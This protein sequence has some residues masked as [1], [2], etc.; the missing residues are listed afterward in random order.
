MSL[1][2]TR[3]IQLSLLFFC[4]GMT[5]L[6]YEVL[7]LK[8]LGLL[9]GNT[10]QAMASTLAAFFLGLAVGGFYWGGK[11]AGWTNRLKLYAM[12]EL[13]VVVCAAGYFGL[14]KLYASIYP[15][16]FECCGNN[17]GLFIAVKFVLSLIILFPAAFFIGG[18]LPVMSHFVAPEQQGLGRKVACLYAVNTLGA[19]AGTVLAGFYLP[20]WLGYR[21][22][23]GLAMMTSLL[24]ATIAWLM[25]GAEVTAQRKKVQSQE[26]EGISAEV[27]VTAFLSGLLMLA[28]QVLWGRMFAQVLQNSVYTFAL[29]LAVFLICLALGGWIARLLMNSRFDTAELVFFVLVAGGL[30]VGISPFLFVGWTDGLHYIGSASGWYKYLGQIFQAALVIMGMPLI[31]LGM[32]FPLL[33]RM[34]ENNGSSGT[35]VGRLVGLNTVGAIAGSLLAGFFILEQMGLWAGIRL[36]SVVYLLTA[37][38][39]LKRLRLTHSNWALLPALGIVLSVSIFDTGKL[40]VVRVDPVNEDESV[41]EVWESSAGTVAAIRQ[42]EQIKIKVNNYY[43]LGGTGSNALEQLQGYLPVLLHERPR[44]VYMLGLGTGITAGGALSYP[45]ESLVVTELLTDVVA[46]S[47]KYF[48]RFTNGLFYDPRVRMLNEDGRNFLRGTND[49]YDVVISDL[50]VPWKAGVGSLYALEHYQTVLQRLNRNGLFMQWLPAY[51]LTQDDF[52]V[53]ARTM[54]EVFPMVTV[55][56]ADFSALKPVIGLVGHRDQ[57]ALSRSAQLFAQNRQELLSHYVGNLTAISRRFEDAPLN[58]DDYPV[59][60]FTAPVSQRLTRSEASRWLAGEDL[61]A[62]MQVLQDAGSGY[63]SELSEDLLKLPEA[64]LHLQRAQWLKYQGKLSGA[65]REMAQYQALMEAWR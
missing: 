35:V 41:L 23:Y 42:G 14:L 56:R 48:G 12:L 19:V 16:L 4:S 7:W 33:I 63:L 28:L 15:L 8:E 64:G 55:W 37:G 5:S 45:I 57:R 62:L 36:M 18:T 58:T 50:F 27:K 31:L 17:V 13:A 9:F 61:I 38:Y 32:V 52:D 34:A 22:S 30:F 46:A 39:W 49:H 60:E 59:I 26:S 44:S 2:L 51:Q 1:S 10:S 53:I 20:L 40:P 11:V 29:V 21:Y 24:V 3:I 25:S 6:I 54:L 47:D 43:T 65:K